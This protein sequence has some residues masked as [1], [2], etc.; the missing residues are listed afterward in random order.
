MQLMLHCDGHG[1]SCLPSKDRDHSLNFL[2]MATCT[3]GVCVGLDLGSQHLAVQARHACTPVALHPGPSF[4]QL[5][6]LSHTHVSSDGTCAPCAWV[7]LWG[8]C[9][10]MHVLPKH[11][12]QAGMWGH[13]QMTGWF[14]MMW[15]V[16][17]QWDGAPEVP[18]CHGL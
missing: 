15:P 2:D 9:A 5:P 13:A 6:A 7:T 3:I 11:G 17:E 8:C 12:H 18:A 14:C 1:S 16:F 4:L 10:S